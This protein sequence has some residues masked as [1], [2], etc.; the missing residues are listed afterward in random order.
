[1]V[2][3][4]EGNVHEVP[5]RDSPTRRCDNSNLSFEEEENDHLIFVA[6]LEFGELA[7]PSLL[8]C[9]RFRYGISHPIQR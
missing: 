6:T 5:S 9:K 4:D 7:H 3:Q 1:M 2:A 8:I